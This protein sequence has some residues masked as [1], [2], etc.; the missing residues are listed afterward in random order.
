MWG[1]LLARISRFAT[2]HGGAWGITP[3]ESSLAGIATNISRDRA[4]W[5]IGCIG[6][7]SCRSVVTSEVC[8]AGGFA[9]A[10][11]VRADIVT[12]TAVLKV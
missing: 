7:P 5:T 6:V 1:S 9:G 12:V 4:L 11:T 10:G 8:K 2:L 3:A